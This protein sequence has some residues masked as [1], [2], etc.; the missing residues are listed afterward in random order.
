MH[1]RSP[2]DGSVPAIAPARAA[3]R[4]STSSEEHKTAIKI[5]KEPATYEHH[6]ERVFFICQFCDAGEQAL[7]ELS[8]LREPF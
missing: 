6:Q 4:D 8:G 7:H 2:S 1:T 3:V 5:V